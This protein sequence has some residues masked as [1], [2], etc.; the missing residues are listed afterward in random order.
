MFW[1]LLI[2]VIGGWGNSR[3][4]IRKTVGDELFEKVQLKDL[5][6]GEQQ[7]RVLIQMTKGNFTLIFFHPR[8]DK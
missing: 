1:I 7:T 5:I 6:S 4:L 2:L 3:Q 8:H